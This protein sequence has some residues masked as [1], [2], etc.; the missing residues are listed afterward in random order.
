[1]GVKESGA[2]ARAAARASSQFQ[3][4]APGFSS[5]VLY[6]PSVVCGFLAYWQFERK[7]W[8]DELIVL[9]ARML[10]EAPRDLFS[11]EDEPRPYENV[12]AA[13]VLQHDSSLFVGPR[14]KSLPG[15]G[16]Q[17]GYLLIT[18]IYDEARKCVAMVNRGWVPKSWKDD[19]EAIS[20]VTGSSRVEVVGVVQPSE[21][22][23]QF[24]PENVPSEGVFHWLDIPSMTA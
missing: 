7:T 9:R 20:K 14:P 16:I 13:G 24:M 17:S 22:P 18:P 21:E 10:T 23:S 6:V 15:L 5:L 1:M 4:E 19:V 12:S 3:E 8:K 2:A 11:L